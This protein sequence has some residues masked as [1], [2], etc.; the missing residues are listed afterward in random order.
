MIKTI[1][2]ANEHGDN[3]Q[4]YWNYK[5][6]FNLKKSSCDILYNLIDKLWYKND[7]WD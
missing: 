2:Y 1:F 5:Y 3:V 7:Y 4:V 6:L